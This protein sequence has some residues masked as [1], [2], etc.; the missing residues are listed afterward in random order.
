MT[1]LTGKHAFSRSSHHNLLDSVLQVC[2]LLFPNT[3]EG[4]P[5]PEE[6]DI[7]CTY[8]A[9]QLRAEVGGQDRQCQDT[10]SHQFLKRESP[11]WTSSLD[12]AP[13]L[14]RDPRH[15]VRL[16]E[17]QSPGQGSVD[18]TVLPYRGVQNIK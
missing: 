16:P 6:N 2:I 13:Y 11:R 1:L 9:I 14:L 8:P 17:F 7:P 4:M 3:H 10:D 12:L 5:R 18:N 15:T